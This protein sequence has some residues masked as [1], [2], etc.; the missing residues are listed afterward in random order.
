MSGIDIHGIGGK[1][2][3]HVELELGACIVNA[4]REGQVGHVESGRRKWNP[5]CDE[6]VSSSSPFIQ[7]TKTY[8]K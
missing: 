6:A 2:S 1:V 7:I 4:F 5:R 3:A 8:V